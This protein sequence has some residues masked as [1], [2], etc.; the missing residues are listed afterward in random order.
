MIPLI[1]FFTAIKMEH[2]TEERVQK[3]NEIWNRM[4]VRL[5]PGFHWN[6]HPFTPY[7]YDADTDSF[8]CMDVSM[9]VDIPTEEITLPKLVY[10]LNDFRTKV[11]LHYRDH[12]NIDL[13]YPCYD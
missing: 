8:K 7:Y 3:I 6:N 1:E 4:K 10:L 5:V 12:H 11:F 2:N 9:P 13:G